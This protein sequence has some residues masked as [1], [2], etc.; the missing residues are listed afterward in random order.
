MGSYTLA[1][2]ILVI[3]FLL[4]MISITKKKILKNLLI[5]ERKKKSHEF[6]LGKYKN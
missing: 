3:L 6:K 5:F 1:E 4:K 2:F